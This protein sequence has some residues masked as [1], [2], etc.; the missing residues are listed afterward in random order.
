VKDAGEIADLVTAAL[1]FEAPRKVRLIR[2]AKGFT[3]QELP[4]FQKI[5]SGEITDSAITDKAQ[6]LA[7]VLTPR[8]YK[9]WQVDI[10]SYGIPVQMNQWSLRI[11]VWAKSK[12]WDAAKAIRNRLITVIRQA[13]LE[14]PNMVPGTYGDT[15]FRLRGDTLNEQ[16]FLPNR[17]VNAGNLV[18]APGIVSVQMDSEESMREGSTRTP[19][20]NPDLPINFDAEAIGVGQNQPLPVDGP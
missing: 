11:N 12:D 13:L 5:N 10:D 4:D 8:L 18:A 6:F 7:L 15:G 17:I 3:E 2:V 1:L 9:T 16:L 14:W 19:I 20:G